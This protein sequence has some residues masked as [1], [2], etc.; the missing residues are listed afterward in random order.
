MKSIKAWAVVTDKLDPLEIY[1]EKD[2]ELSKGER[3]VR[4]I[5]SLDEEEVDKQT[6]K[7]TRQT[8]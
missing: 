8:L 7:R 4:V 1:K 6:K 3:I 2:V 5:I